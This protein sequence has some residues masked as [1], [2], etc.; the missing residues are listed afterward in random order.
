MGSRYP[1]DESLRRGSS[2]YLLDKAMPHKRVQ[3]TKCRI[4][5]KVSAQLTDGVC[6]KCRSESKNVKN[7]WFEGYKGRIGRPV[8]G[9]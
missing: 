9:P 3:P 1:A 2:Q 7:A 6:E 8:V 5:G 4:C